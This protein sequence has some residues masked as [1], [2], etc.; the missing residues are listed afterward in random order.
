MREEGWADPL[1]MWAEGMTHACE[2]ITL[3]QT[4]FASGNKYLVVMQR[5]KARL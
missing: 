2:N 3:F 4:L 1:P 5:Y